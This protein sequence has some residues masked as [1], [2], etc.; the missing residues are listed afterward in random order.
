MARTSKAPPSTRSPSNVWSKERT[1]NTR[2]AMLSHGI[3][4]T[5]RRTEETQL[6]NAER[7][8]VHASLVRN[9]SDLPKR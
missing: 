8:R 6:M 5:V 3:D 9:A 1:A 4:I 7:L 2:G